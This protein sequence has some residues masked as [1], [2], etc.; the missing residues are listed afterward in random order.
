MEQEILYKLQAVAI[1]IDRLS[2]T[3]KKTATN[4][5][6]LYKCII[7]SPP[8]VNGMVLLRKF[9]Q[10]AMLRALWAQMQDGQQG[11]S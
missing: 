4:I 9:V 8:Q 5:L 3:D 7:F 10:I 6:I 11:F 1:L 2:S